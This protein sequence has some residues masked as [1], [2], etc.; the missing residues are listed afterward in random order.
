MVYRSQ[1]KEI[2]HS[3]HV[4]YW[5]VH[6]RHSSGDG[7]KCRA[8][9]SHVSDLG[10]ISVS[11]IRVEAFL[12]GLL[13]VVSGLLRFSSRDSS[14]TCAKVPLILITQIQLRSLHRT[15]LHGLVSYSTT[16]EDHLAIR[17]LGIRMPGRNL[18]KKTIRRSRIRSRT[19]VGRQ[20]RMTRYSLG[21][22]GA[23]S[24]RTKLFVPK[25]DPG[26]PF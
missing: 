25:T 17:S 24:F 20:L 23:R 18:R 19:F 21:L 5:G 12:N 11:L 15:S 6:D 9:G 3:L 2:Q 13:N 7:S 8:E 4:Q 14:W 1:A 26:S 10:S 22:S 16:S